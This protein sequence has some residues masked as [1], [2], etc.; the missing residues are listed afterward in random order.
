M[1]PQETTAIIIGGKVKIMIKLRSIF[2]RIS[3]TY[4]SLL[5]NFYILAIQQGQKRSIETKKPISFSGTPLPWYTYSAIEYLNQFDFS[6]L[7][8]F[9]FG[10]G[11]STL[12]WAHKAKTVISIEHDIEWYNHIKMHLK[13]KKNIYLREKEKSYVGYLKEIGL[14]FDVIIIDGKWRNAC[15][16]VALTK[17]RDD[18]LIIFD[19]SDWFPKATQFLRVNGFFQIDFNGFGPIN[20]YCWTTSIFIKSGTRMQNNFKNPEPIGGL[21]KNDDE[22]G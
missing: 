2:R 9:E 5:H 10:C 16:K 8:I 22:K 13:N 18:G 20:N 4:N 1:N 12:F 7:S 14:M 21:K 17:I 19:N 3:P 6:Q 11:Y 15:T